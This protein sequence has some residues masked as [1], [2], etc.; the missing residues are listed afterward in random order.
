MYPSVKA[1][2]RA[3]NEPFEGVVPWMYL[4][5]K[6]LV[7]VGVGNLIDPVELA[8]QL[9]FR[10]RAEPHVAASPGQIAEEWQKIKSNSAL[11]KAGWRACEP[12]TRLGLDDA[13]IDA[14]IAARLTGNEASLRKKESFREFD[15][16]PADAQLGLLSMAWALGPGGPPGFARF[17]AACRNLDFAAA[18][19]NCAINEQGNPGI[20][21][22]NRA[23]R[24]LFR[25][26]AVVRADG[27]GAA[28]DPSELRYPA[29]LA[30][31][32]PVAD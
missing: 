5:V 6:G 20:A 2:F 28:H 25:N 26:A 14:L 17:A 3:F 24:T 29:V 31:E 12:L 16:W 11:A 9:P 19:A 30:G 7:T 1:A 4:D 13:A 21:P 22:R 32:H 10:F 18:A 27:A 15:A 8:V 23:N